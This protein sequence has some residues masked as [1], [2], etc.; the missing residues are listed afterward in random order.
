MPS[1]C[2]KMRWMPELETNSPNFAICKIVTNAIELL[3]WD[4][5]QKTYKLDVN[6]HLNWKTAAKDQLY[7]RHFEKTTKQ[8]E[9]YSR[10]FTT[11][12]S[13]TENNNQWEIQCTFFTFEVEKSESW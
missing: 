12:F 2:R 6:S 4:W 3:H 7:R 10:Y 9:K 8:M 5:G 1:G 11:L 13:R